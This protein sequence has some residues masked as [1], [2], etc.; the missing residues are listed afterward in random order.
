[1]ADRENVKIV[2]SAALIVVVASMGIYAFIY[3]DKISQMLPNWQ[4]KGKTERM[5]SDE[6]TD[7]S[8][9][10]PIPSGMEPSDEDKEYLGYKT[11]PETKNYPDIPL[12]KETQ[13][14]PKSDPTASFTGTESKSD[15]M[16]PANKMI[17]SYPKETTGIVDS[18][19]KSDSDN[20]GMKTS[21]DSNKT[22]TKTTEYKPNVDRNWTEKKPT[23][24]T[25]PTDTKKLSSDKKKS[26]DKKQT[27][28][29][30]QTSVTKNTT[31]T[32]YPKSTTT[33]KN[34]SS[35][36]NT[37][38]SKVS[39]VKNSTTSSSAKSNDMNERIRNLESKLN[40]HMQDTGKRLDGIERRLEKLERQLESR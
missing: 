33:V 11:D 12:N 25:A 29:R 37:S 17:E 14:P 26:S 21:V 3:R 30:K 8:S 9:P 23:T 28:D 27:S 16:N 34:T 31:K 5:I 39:N 13:S 2:I 15:Q 10:L 18:P 35:K 1:M 4:T 6:G 22:T 19:K 32:T 40:V 38:A 36:Q 20:S 7:S 24:R